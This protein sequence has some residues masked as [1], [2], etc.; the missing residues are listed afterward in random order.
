MKS[1]ENHIG[2]FFVFGKTRR[3]A[4][5]DRRVLGWFGEKTCR[6]RL[7]AE[8][9]ENSL[10]RLLCLRGLAGCAGAQKWNIH[11]LLLQHRRLLKQIL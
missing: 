6:K 7:L 9:L 1:R 10:L 5:K 11:L 3:E 2:G 4:H 8:V